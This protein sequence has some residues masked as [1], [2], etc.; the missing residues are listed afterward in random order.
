[1]AVGHFEA[2]GVGEDFAVGSESGRVDGAGSVGGLFDALGVGVGVDFDLLV[3]GVASREL[4]GVS[5]LA[6]DRFEVGFGF[7]H[8]MGALIEF[9]DLRRRIC[10]RR[11]VED[12]LGVLVG[13]PTLSLQRGFG[14]GAAQLGHRRNPGADPAGRVAPDGSCPPS[15]AEAVQN[16]FWTSSW[17]MVVMFWPAAIA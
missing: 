3:A 13:S 2:V 9:G 12:L 17:I 14:I 4:A 15:P 1:M 5:G 8:W 16:G 6:G 10:P 11:R 7:R